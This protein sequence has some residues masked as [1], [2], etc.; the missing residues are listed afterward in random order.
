M[1]GSLCRFK[2]AARPGWRTK[3]DPAGGWWMPWSSTLAA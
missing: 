3:A 2:L 1:A